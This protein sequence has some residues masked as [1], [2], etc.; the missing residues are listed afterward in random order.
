MNQS[1]NVIPC[2]RTIICTSND[3]FF[4]ICLGGKRAIPNKINI[5]VNSETYPDSCH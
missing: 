1:P 3:V 4:E 2:G 5:H